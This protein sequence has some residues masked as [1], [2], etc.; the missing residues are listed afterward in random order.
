MFRVPRSLFRP[1]LP[2]ILAAERSATN[3]WMSSATR[4]MTHLAAMPPRMPMATVI[5][6]PAAIQPLISDAAAP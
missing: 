2:W 1:V 4:W 5:Q 6:V 3:H